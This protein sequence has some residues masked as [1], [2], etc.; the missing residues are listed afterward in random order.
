M[1]GREMTK[2]GVADIILLILLGLAF[3]VGV[4]FGSHVWP[5]SG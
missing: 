3:A 5:V 2:N 1:D 4:W